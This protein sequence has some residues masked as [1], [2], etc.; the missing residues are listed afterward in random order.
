MNGQLIE[1]GLIELK[2]DDQVCGL[3]IART[4]A[5]DLVIIGMTREE[6][7]DYGSVLYG[8]V[9]VA[10]SAAPKEAE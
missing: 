5:P 2:P 4:G 1:L 7:R 10:I 8:D 9:Q 3:R 6:V